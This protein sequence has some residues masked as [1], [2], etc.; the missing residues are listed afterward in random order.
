M[1]FYCVVIIFVVVVVVVVVLSSPV[2]SANSPR[3]HKP[4]AHHL[5]SKTTLDPLLR[6]YF[7]HCRSQN[8]RRSE[9]G[10]YSLRN[11]PNYTLNSTLGE[12]ESRH[13]VWEKIKNLL[14]LAGIEPRLFSD[15]T[16]NLVIPPQ[17]ST[18]LAV[19]IP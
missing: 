1:P 12:P 13:D 4:N 19:C 11:M 8:H 15:A 9:G 10:L 14:P 5:C 7:S 18:L 16:R 6:Q 2:R 3:V 17:L